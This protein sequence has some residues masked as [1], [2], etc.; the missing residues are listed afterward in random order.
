MGISKIKKIL[1][2]K[3]SIIN[4]Q[5]IIK[6]YKGKLKKLLLYKCKWFNH[7][8]TFL[9]IYYKNNEFKVG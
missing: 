7:K 5:N 4:V 3:S 1:F 9:N 2:F 8:N 6:I